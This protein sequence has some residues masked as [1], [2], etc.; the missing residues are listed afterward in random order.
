MSSDT[1]DPVLQI[2]LN[3]E[4]LAIRKPATVASLIVLRHPSPPFAV[5]VNKELVRRPEYDSKPLRDGDTV[6]IVTL[7]GGG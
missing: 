3:G 7:V 6:E 4:R 5:E 1:K 2:E